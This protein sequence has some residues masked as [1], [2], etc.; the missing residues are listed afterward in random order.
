ML[1]ITMSCQE[2]P[3]ADLPPATQEGKNTLACLI[4]NNRWTQ[5]SSDFK[6]SSSIAYY[7]SGP[8]T[9]L[10]RGRDDTKRQFIGFAITNYDGKLGAYKLD[11]SCTDL[12]Q[13]CANLGFYNTDPSPSVSSNTIYL[14]DFKNTG[15][16]TIT[17][18]TPSFVSGTFEFMARHKVTGKTV[19]ITNGRFDMPYRTSY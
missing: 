5:Y 4:D 6:Q 12:P 10:I 15:Q 11:S 1:L 16:V 2:D 19:R 14:T 9:L 13:V 3:A 8:K 17:R 7:F 18:H